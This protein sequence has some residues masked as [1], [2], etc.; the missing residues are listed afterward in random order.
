MPLRNG[1]VEGGD[2]GDVDWLLKKKER[3]GEVDGLNGAMRGK[4]PDAGVGNGDGGVV[5]PESEEP[6][7]DSEPERR[8]PSAMGMGSEWVKFFS[9][10]DIVQNVGLLGSKNG[11]RD[12]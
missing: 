10:E 12:E 6:E 3:M 1:N 7:S 11:M 2:F 8:R 9:S 4:V 5:D